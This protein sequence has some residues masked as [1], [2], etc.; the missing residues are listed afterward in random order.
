MSEALNETAY[1]DTPEANDVEVNEIS[2]DEVE[3]RETD[4]L[5]DIIKA[6][7]AAGGNYRSFIDRTKAL[8]FK[9]AM[10]DSGGVMTTASSRLGVNRGSFRKWG[11]VR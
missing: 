7:V 8:F 1:E 4:D 9:H 6:H 2:V 11:E 3:F 5:S 10:D